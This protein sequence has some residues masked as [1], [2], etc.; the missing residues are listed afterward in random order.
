MFPVSCLLKL[1]LKLFEDFQPFRFPYLRVSQLFLFP[2]LRISQLFLFP[3]SLCFFNYY[4]LL[5]PLR[6][7]S[8]GCLLISL[9]FSTII[10]ISKLVLAGSYPW[11]CSPPLVPWRPS[12]VSPPG[13]AGVG[14]QVAYLRPGV[15]D[16]PVMAER[17]LL[18]GFRSGAAF[19]GRLGGARV[20]PR[21][22]PFCRG[23]HRSSGDGTWCRQ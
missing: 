1:F 19:G 12:G 11:C 23:P 21:R 15:T 20:A 10:V 6:F 9:C 18:V 2:I 8:Y 3:I 7:L 4:C 5:I 13:G 16:P 22:R 17:A 14:A